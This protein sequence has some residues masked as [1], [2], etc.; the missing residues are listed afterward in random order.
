MVEITRAFVLGTRRSLR[1][2]VRKYGVIEPEK[3]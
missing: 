1:D 2:T 3:K